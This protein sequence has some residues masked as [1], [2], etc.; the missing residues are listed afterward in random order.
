MIH[1][2]A[3][4]GKVYDPSSRLYWFT[5]ACL[6]FFTV[7]LAWVLSDDA[8][9]MP[10]PNPF[11]NSDSSALP[12]IGVSLLFHLGLHTLWHT[13]YFALPFTLYGIVITLGQIVVACFLFSLMGNLSLQQISGGAAFGLAAS[14]LVAFP[15]YAYLVPL[16]CSYK[17]RKDS[18]AWRYLGMRPMPERPGLEWCLM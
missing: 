3:W 13:R 14:A 9:A 16:I 11:C 17:P 12:P 4:W 18:W 8:I 7:I 15:Y 5:F 1:Y 6:P 10:P 2:S